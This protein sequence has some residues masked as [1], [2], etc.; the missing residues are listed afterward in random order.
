MEIK[1]RG[2]TENIKE[3]ENFVFKT[4]NKNEKSIVKVKK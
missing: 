3:A 4:L 1:N 2:T